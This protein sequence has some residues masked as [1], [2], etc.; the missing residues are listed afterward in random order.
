M[1]NFKILIILLT[2]LFFIA[3]PATAADVTFE[4][5]ANTEPDLAGYKL[6]S[7]N[8]SGVY[9]PATVV[10]VGKVTTHVLSN[11]AD[12]KWFWALTAYDASGNES[13]KSNE[14]SMTIDTVGPGAPAAFRVI[15]SAVSVSVEVE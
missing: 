14:V 8:E 2:F 11:V 5:D 9:D 15:L 10:D 12:G 6:Y 7:G 13:K 1:Q 3:A 4:W